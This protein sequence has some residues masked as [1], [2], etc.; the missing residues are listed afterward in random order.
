[1]LVYINN[2]FFHRTHFIQGVVLRR[3]G[4]FLRP[5]TPTGRRETE[6]THSFHRD[7]HLRSAINTIT[8]PIY[9]A[10]ADTQHPINR[11][12]TREEVYAASAARNKRERK[13]I[14]HTH[15]LGNFS[16]HLAGALK[17]SHLALRVR[18]W[19]VGLRELVISIV[20]L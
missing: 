12:V 15:T 3:A 10:R 13:E 11:L 16:Q 14:A 9:F 17:I 7:S 2:R 19:R 4:D 18:W 20:S 1:M 8:P 5:A 6:L